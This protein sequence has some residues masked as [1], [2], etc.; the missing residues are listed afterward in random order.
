VIRSWWRSRVLHG[1]LLVALLSAWSAIRDPGREEKTS[2]RLA[3]LERGGGDPRAPSSTFCRGSRDPPAPNGALAH[4]ELAAEAAPVSLRFG[5]DVRL[6]SA[7]FKEYDRPIRFFERLASA[8]GPLPEPQL[9]LAL[10]YVDKMPDHMMGLV[11]QSKLSNL[12]IAKL[13]SILKDDPELAGKTETRWAALYALGLNHLYWPKAMKHAPLA[14]DAFKQCLALQTEAMTVPA[15][16]DDRPRR[17]GPLRQKPYFVL[18]WIALGDAYVKDGKH[19][20]ARAIW[21]EALGALPDDPRLKS[22]LAVAGDQEITKFVEQKRGL[23][24]VVDTDL[25]IRRAP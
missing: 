13:E 11:G 2:V 6:A 4:L 1:L 7:R 15:E 3:R 16:Q 5:N 18:P 10:A 9:Q 17:E 24:S 14:I 25:S 21:R 12:S 19:E 20:S 23:G 8:N 22:R